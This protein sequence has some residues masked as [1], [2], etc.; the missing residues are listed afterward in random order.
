MDSA[1]VLYSDE[2]FGNVRIL[3]NFYFVRFVFTSVISNSLALNHVRSDCVVH[4]HPMHTCLV[5][6]V[7]LVVRLRLVT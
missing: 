6:C 5:M 1:S 3:V 4:V 7:R 2:Y